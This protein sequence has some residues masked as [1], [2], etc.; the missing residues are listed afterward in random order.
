M[1]SQTLLLLRHAKSDWP[2]GVPD[3]ERPLAP[4]GEK[5]AKAVGR[6]LAA[7]DLVPDQV[8]SSP[9][10]RAIETAARVLRVAGG[11][12]DLDTDQRLYDGA[13]DEL[14]VE[15]LPASGRLLL[16]GHEPEMA[17]LLMRSTGAQARMPTAAL[18]VIE[19]ELD[20]LHRLTVDPWLGPCGV[21]QL[22]VPP[23]MLPKG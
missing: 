8:I 5:A 11:T 17:E 21:L 13:A 22:L 18:A 14:L 9:A 4:R 20:H 12:A 3:R 16:V 2:V 10:R 15:R 1:V 7:N 19:V 23:S 6:F